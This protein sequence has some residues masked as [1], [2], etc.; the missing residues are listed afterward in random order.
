MS[1]GLRT[2]LR[3]LRPWGRTWRRSR[4]IH[5]WRIHCER[6]WCSTGTR[7]RSGRAGRAMPTRYRHVDRL[8]NNGANSLSLRADSLLNTGGN[9]RLLYRNRSVCP[10]IVCCER[11]ALIV[12]FTQIG[13]G[14]FCHWLAWRWCGRM[15]CDWWLGHHCLEIGSIG[16]TKSE[17]RW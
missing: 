13:V 16:K 10:S 3:G 17:S 5:S 15:T 8:S 6:I 4:C 12:G 1:G 14:R 7:S 9:R 2:A 11:I